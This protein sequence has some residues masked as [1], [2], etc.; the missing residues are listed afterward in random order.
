MTHLLSRASLVCC[1]TLL[2][3]ISACGGKPKAVAEVEPLVTITTA[4]LSDVTDTVTFTGTINARDEMPISLDGESARIAAILVEVGDRVRKGQVLARLNPSMVA[5]QVASLRASLEQARSSAEL[6]A[7]DYR[8]GQ[9]VAASGA[10]S[11]EEIERRRT[12]AANA[13]ATVRVAQ[14]QLAESRAR[15]GRTEIR[16]P[17]DGVVLTRSAEVG[18]TATIGGEP[19]FRLGRGGDIE[20][21]GQV[22]EQ[23]LPKLAVGQTVQVRVTGTANAFPGT[24]RLLGAVID[25]QNRM[26]SIRVSVKQDRNL[27]PGAFARG[28]AV[29]GQAKHPVLPQTAVLTDLKGNYVLIVDSNNI[30]QRR[31]VKVISTRGGGVVIDTGLKGGEAV[32]TTAAAFLR[33]GEKVRTLGAKS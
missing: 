5:P 15:L 17:A 14:A 29:V 20:M 1:T 4:S 6:A 7:A 25:A 2:L 16:A 22:A 10:L 30:V 23:D 27:R 26:G 33:E 32:I 24:V 21:R 31:D 11:A 12:V 8:R 9:A 19:L 28:E 18:Q 3:T 13:Q